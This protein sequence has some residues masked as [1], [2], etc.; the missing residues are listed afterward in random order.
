MATN[1]KKQN[2]RS[3]LLVICDFTLVSY[4]TYLMYV[5]LD[6]YYFDGSVNTLK[7]LTTTFLF[8]FLI[9]ISSLS[10][11]LYE[12]KLRETFRGII[13]RIFV[14]VGIAYF[15]IEIVSA[16]IGTSLK[17]HPYFLPASAAVSIIM[18]TSPKLRQT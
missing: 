18:S 15:C 8:T 16:T 6:N 14:S 12:S 9:V 2:K 13:R 10:V 1:N 5:M 11:G 3:N 7:V 17:I 4:I